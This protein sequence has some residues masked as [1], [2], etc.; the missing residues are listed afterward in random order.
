MRATDRRLEA[1]ESGTRAWS[2]GPHGSN[3]SLDRNP[4]FGAFIRME[5]KSW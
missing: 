3:V 2:Q 4:L 5:N 1:K